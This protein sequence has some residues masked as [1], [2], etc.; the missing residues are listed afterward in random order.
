VHASTL[1]A[2]CLVAFFAAVALLVTWP[3]GAHLTTHLPLGTVRVPTVALF[4]LWTLEWNADRLGHGYANYWNAPIFH[5]TPLAFALSEP[6]PLTGVAFALV[7]AFAG[8]VA[9]Y[10]IVLIAILVGNGLAVRHLARAMGAERLTATLAGALAVGLPFSLLELGVL[11]LL[12]LFPPIL[13]LAELHQL[14]REPGRTPAL[15]LAVWIA[16][17]FFTCAYHAAFLSV[18]IALGALV[19]SRRGARQRWLLALAG[20]CLLALAACAPLVLAQHEALSG[21]ERSATRIRDGSASARRYWQADPRT[22]AAAAPFLRGRP[23]ARNLYPGAVL[24]AL[25]LAGFLHERRGH[26]RRWIAFCATGLG[27]ALLVSFGRRIEIAG[28]IPYEFVFEHAW[29]GF[30][31]LRS[32]YRCAAFAHLFLVALASGGLTALQ[33]IGLRVRGRRAGPALAVLVTALALVETTPRPQALHRFRDDAMSAPWVSWLRAH[34]GGAV[35]M[36]PPEKGARV[37]DFAP[38][39]LAM[40]QGL[41]HGHALANGY[42]GFFPRR[43]RIL[44]GTLRGFPDRRSLR[45]LSDAGCRYAVVESTWLRDRARDE[46]RWAGLR[47]VHEDAERTIFALPAPAHSASATARTGR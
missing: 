45:L 13:C 46:H 7:R 42:S 12:V 29:P 19:L 27:V 47:A 23:D 4:N 17:T 21:Y 18:F 24:C 15:R 8:P 36:V 31:R 39:T 9:A 43:A 41:R 40:L 28:V 30:S 32:P 6:Q 10:D 11:Q 2:I 38:T 1:R 35:V 34:P 20:S 25:A 3:L 33:R 22:L 26:D 44:R 5:P 16:V 37:A 14:Q